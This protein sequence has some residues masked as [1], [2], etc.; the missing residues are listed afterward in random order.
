MSM[1]SRL[2]SLRS[3]SWS[4]IS[5]LSL[6]GG[7]LALALAACGSSSTAAPAAGSSSTAAGASSA[8]PVSIKSGFGTATIPSAPSRVVVIGT[9]T[10]DLDA[11]LAL[12]VTPV[13][14]F[15]KVYTEPDGVPPWLK[16]TLDPAKT[17]IVNA[18]AGVSAEQVAGY[19]P[20]L[21][22]ATGDYGL[23]SE[24]ATL[25]KIAPTVGYATAWGG[26]SWQQHVQVVGQALGKSSA[27]TDLI[28]KTQNDIA[29]VKAANTGAA[30]KTF[31]ASVGNTPGKIYTLVSDSDFA[32]KLIEQLGLTLS[33][34]VTGLSQQQ[35]GS[36]TGALSP[37][38]YDKL[39]ADAVI[40]AFTS[41]DLQNAFQSSQLVKTIVDGTGYFVVDMQTITQLR[42]PS[43]LGIPWVLGQL[44]PVLQKLDAA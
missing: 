24:Y 12:G 28:D 25:S 20:D 40:I 13:A 27:A 5:V 39:K 29:A 11:V 33:S 21:I 38:Q 34:T 1:S 22:L 41:T 23:D 31:T 37:E 6:V 30:G 35:A 2:T 9:S 32:V 3:R 18:D 4:R 19:D 8:F 26:Q 15:S 16:G 36:P 42:E 17:K 14:F 10:D 44:K 7:A 43:V